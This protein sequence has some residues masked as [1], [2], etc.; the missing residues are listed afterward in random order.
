MRTII[1]AALVAACHLVTD[2]MPAHAVKRPTPA[3]SAPAA[4]S[5]SALVRGPLIWPGHAVS[6]DDA[7]RLCNLE[8]DDTAPLHLRLTIPF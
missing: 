8:L 3:L 4:S 7:G 1:L 2:A 6:A 5:L